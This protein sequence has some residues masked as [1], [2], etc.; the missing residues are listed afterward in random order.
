MELLKMMTIMT[1][2]ERGHYRLVAAADGDNEKVQALLD[3]GRDRSLCTNNF[4]NK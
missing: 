2:N 1:E 4:T 3:A